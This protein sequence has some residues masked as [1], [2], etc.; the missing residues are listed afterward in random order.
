MEEINMIVEKGKPEDMKELAYMMEEMIDKLDENCAKK[1]KRKLYEMAYGKVLNKEMATEWVNSMKPSGKWTLEET[2]S[3][4][5][6]ANIKDLDFYVVMN[7]LYSDYH[8]IL[9]EDTEMY[10]KLAVAW[11]TD[12]DVAKDKTYNYRVYVVE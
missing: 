5:P 10:I 7:M 6:N 3:V 9:G 1:Y 4:K 11:L 8:E 2:T 12:E